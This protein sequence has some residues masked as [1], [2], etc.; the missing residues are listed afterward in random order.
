[1]LLPRDVKPD[2]TLTLRIDSVILKCLC[3]QGVLGRTYDVSSY[4]I[5]VLIYY[6]VKLAEALNYELCNLVT[7]L[8]DFQYCSFH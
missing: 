5:D 6:T 3:Q 4:I 7:S 2:K 8:Y 1:M